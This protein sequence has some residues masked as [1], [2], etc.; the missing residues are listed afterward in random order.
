MHIH[1]YQSSRRPPI[2]WLLRSGLIGIV[3]TVSWIQGLD[4]QRNS[5]NFAAPLAA[6]AQTVTNEEVRSYAESVVEMDTD[7]IETYNQ[8]SDFLT[9]QG[10][11]VTDY[12]L[13]CPNAE[14]LSDVPRNVR[15]RVR[16][17]LVNYC[18]EARRIVETNGL[19][20]QQFNAI[21]AAHREDAELAQRIQSAI[22]TIQQ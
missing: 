8:I 11:D 19:T 10:L 16:S 20:V 14:S 21:T 22:A 18:N 17:L 7:R 3:T 15:S 2:R 4:I 1:N 9:S 6:Q 12:D 13:S 5:A